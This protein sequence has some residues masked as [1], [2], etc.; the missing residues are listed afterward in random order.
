MSEAEDL[1]LGDSQAEFVEL[2][3][4][5]D[6]GERESATLRVADGVTTRIRE[7]NE[8]ALEIEVVLSEPVVLNEP[9]LLGQNAA[10]RLFGD[11]KL[12]LK[13]VFETPMAMEPDFRLR[14]DT[15]SGDDRVT[16]YVATLRRSDGASVREN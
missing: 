16:V 7:K 6:K 11:I 1:S 13:T 3:V 12:S 9:P 10:P 5:I 2:V 4:G 14:D 15:E 8:D